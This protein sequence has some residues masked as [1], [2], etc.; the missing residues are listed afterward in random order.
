MAKIIDPALTPVLTK[1]N[2]DLNRV[3]LL[4]DF[5]SRT[6]G[7]NRSPYARTYCDEVSGLRYLVASGLPMVDAFGQ[8][9]DLTW[10]DKDGVYSNGNNIF[11]SVYKDGETTLTALSDQPSGAKKGDQV[12]YRPQFSIGG[13]EVKPVSLAPKLLEVDPV[14]NEYGN[15]VLEWDYGI[16]RRRLRLIEGKILGSWVFTSKPAGDVVIRYNQKGNLR[17]RLPMAKDDDVEVI[18]AAYF[19]RPGPR[20][21]PVTISDTQ[22]FYPDASPET[23]SVDGHVRADNLNT[24]AGLWTA[25]AGDFAFDAQTQTYPCYLYSGSNAG[26]WYTITRNAFLFDTS[27]IGSSGVVTNATFSLYGVSKQ[28]LIVITPSVN[29]Y[30]VNLQSNTA[31]VLT[32]WLY[33]R[34]GTTAYCDTAITYAAYDA[35]GWNDWALNSTGIAAVN[36]SGITKISTRD[37]YDRN[38]V[39]PTT[40]HYLQPTNMNCYTADQGGTTKPK[41]VVTWYVPG[42]YPIIGGYH[43]IRTEGG[44]V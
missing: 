35:A 3:K 5:A 32:D 44:D 1:A 43:I 28:D 16:C 9:H 2:V 31:I 12:T 36:V 38:N 19:D 14:N 26:N 25:A 27:S 30:S 8:S 33:T 20:G 11:R 17:L 39:Q 21:W 24:W 6:S 18:P 34:W 4:Q 29:I 37:Y 22:A 41:L 42:P 15:N 13:V 23:T 7:K 40:T 10:Y